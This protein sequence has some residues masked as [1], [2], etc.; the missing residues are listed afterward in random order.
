MRRFLLAAL[1]LLPLF[2][3]ACTGPAAATGPAALADI[4]MYHG[5]MGAGQYRVQVTAAG[6]MTVDLQPGPGSIQHA[7]A[8][9]TPQQIT[10]LAKA[11]QGWKDLQAL[12]P[13]D[14]T[15]LIQI[16]YDG[17][18]VESHDLT[19]APANYVA[20]KAL[21]DDIAHQVMLASTRPAPPPP[22]SPPAPA[23][24]LNPRP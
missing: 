5:V 22:A 9:L 4:R 6:D 17:Y 15:I 20:A 16:T 7:A 23:G 18:M 10:A 12:Y 14:W 2:L 1:C 13:G 8:H 19:Q 24:L 3:A 21:L 11:F